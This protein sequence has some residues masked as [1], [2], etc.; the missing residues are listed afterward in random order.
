M[1][2]EEGKRMTELQSGKSGCHTPGYFAYE[3]QIFARV[4][5]SAKKCK[6]VREPGGKKRGG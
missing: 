1:I 5:K 6:R 2:A 3:W 4:R